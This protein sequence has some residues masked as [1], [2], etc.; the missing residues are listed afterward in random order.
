MEMELLKPSNQE[1][2]NHFDAQ[3]VQ[4]I[5]QCSRP[6]EEQGSDF[7][8]NLDGG[9]MTLVLTTINQCVSRIRQL[10]EQD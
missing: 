4:T 5:N 10:Q 2:I 1:D 3:N 9:G 7:V 6:E 8:Y